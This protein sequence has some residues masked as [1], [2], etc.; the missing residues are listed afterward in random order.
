M[1]FCVRASN[2]G[3]RIGKDAFVADGRTIPF[4][5]SP[6]AN[7]NGVHGEFRKE[8]MDVK[9]VVRV[10]VDFLLTEMQ[11]RQNECGRFGDSRRRGNVTHICKAEAQ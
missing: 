1:T 11:S 4:E 2:V 8:G 6:T 7:G 5:A 9:C 10:K 3:R